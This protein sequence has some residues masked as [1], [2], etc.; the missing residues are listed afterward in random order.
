LEFTNKK[1]RPTYKALVRKKFKEPGPTLTKLGWGTRTYRIVS[2]SYSIEIF[3]LMV[4]A[5]GIAFYT[6]LGAPLVGHLAADFPEFGE[7][8]L[9]HAFFQDFDSTAFQ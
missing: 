8:F 2:F 4:T 9:A 7:K 1:L 3:F 5:E 6:V